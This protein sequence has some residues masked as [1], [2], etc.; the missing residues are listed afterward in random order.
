MQP[1]YEQF[2]SL[3][4]L[5]HVRLDYKCTCVFSLEYNVLTTYA[6]YCVPELNEYIDTL[7]EDFAKHGTVD[8]FQ[9]IRATTTSSSESASTHSRSRTRAT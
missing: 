6:R 4:K 1:S 3:M 2:V 9:E 8:T 7:V 5:I